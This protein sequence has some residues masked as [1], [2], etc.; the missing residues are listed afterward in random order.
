[1][2]KI[3]DTPAWRKR[4]AEFIKGKS[5]ER[6]GSKEYLSIHHPQPPN[7]LTDEDYL[8]FKGTMIL[9]RRCHW[10]V[11]QGGSKEDGMINAE[12]EW[13]K[14]G[15]IKNDRCKQPGG[16]KSRDRVKKGLCSWE[17]ATCAGEIRVCEWCGIPY[18][19][20]HF[21]KHRTVRRRE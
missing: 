20:Y 17:C 2:V 21:N 1:M 18:C 19:E 15:Y 13:K 4:R 3:Y 7:T 5:C 16:A 11:Q 9:C 8:S 10:I 14:L 6:C 12:A